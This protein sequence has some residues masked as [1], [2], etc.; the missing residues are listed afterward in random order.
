MRKLAYGVLFAAVIP[1]L[2][3]FWARALDRVVTLPAFAL[4]RS[5]SRSCSSASRSCWPASGRCAASATDGR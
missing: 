4:R 3:A 5:V 1:L 2:L